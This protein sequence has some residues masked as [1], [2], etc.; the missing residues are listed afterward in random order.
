VLQKLQQTA[1]CITTA[2]VRRFG[3]VW[4]T[5]GAPPCLLRHRLFPRAL[6]QYTL[7]IR[8]SGLH[9]LE[10][11]HLPSDNY[12]TYYIQTF[13]DNLVQHVSTIPRSNLLS[14]HPTLLFLTISHNHPTPPITTSLHP[15]TTLQQLHQQHP[16]HSPPPHPYF[17]PPPT[18]STYA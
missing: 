15:Q 18:P 10:Y 8:N 1:V 11:G 14:P 7:Q 12:A 5:T 17:A 9:A 2:F 13:L 6:I 3:L 16:Q 4:E